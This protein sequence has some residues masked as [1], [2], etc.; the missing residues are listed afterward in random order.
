[1]IKKE[2]LRETAFGDFRISLIRFEAGGARISI[3]P[4]EPTKL[5]DN[6]LFTPSFTHSNFPSN[7]PWIDFYSTKAGTFEAQILA[8]SGRNEDISKYT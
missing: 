5:V 2:I 1:M 8:Q 7:S 4:K 6:F 3:G